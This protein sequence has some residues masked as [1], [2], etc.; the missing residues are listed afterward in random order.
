MVVTP[1]P[2]PATRTGPARGIALAVLGLAAVAAAVAPSA[3]AQ[4][5]EG[6]PSFRVTKTQ[7]VETLNRLAGCWVG[8]NPWGEPSRVS[9]DLSADDT[10]ILE[11]LEQRGQVP[12][13][14]A[15]YI[16]GETP[17][18]HHFCSYGSQIRFRAEPGDDPDVL[19]F[20]FMDATNIK[21]WE[22]DDHMTYVTFRFLDE[23]RLEIEW[24][25][26]QRGKDL[27]Q[28][29]PFTRVE[30]GCDVRRSDVWH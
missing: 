11:Y 9:Y 6:N 27:K 23:D 29:F 8:K 2:I 5:F 26:H 21:S 17:M 14:S 30:E 4:E 16:D 13:Y 18:I 28:I 19:H 12:M 1:K 15:I 3:R 24:G 25:L 20:G 10:V 7:A 22:E